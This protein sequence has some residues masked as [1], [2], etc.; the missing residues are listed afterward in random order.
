M[1][2]M[3]ERHAVAPRI[4]IT[5]RIAEPGIDLLRRELPQALIDERFG[6]QPAHLHR[7]IG[8]YTALIIR[9]QTRVTED[10]L[11]AARYLHNAE[12]L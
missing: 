8:E 3:A 10:V 11:A 2:M 5:E 9:S 6:L 1:L 7:L 4:L 12:V